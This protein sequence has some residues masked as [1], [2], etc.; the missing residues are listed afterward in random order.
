ML[1]IAF[2]PDY[3]LKLPE[4][5]RFPMEKYELL[6]KQL[7][8][9]GIVEHEAFFEPKYPEEKY[10]LNVHT[11][12]YLDNLQKLNLDRK[13]ILKMGFPLTEALVKREMLMVGGTIESAKYALQTGIGL[14]IAGGTHHAYPGHAEGFCLL[15]DHA[16]AA[17]YLQSKGLA[18]KILII[19]LDVHQG[20]GTAKIFENDLNVFTF[21]MHA[22]NN[23]P[24]KKEKSDLDIALKDHTKDEQ[25]L[26][27][28]KNYLPQLLNHYH[29]DFIFYQS[30][31]DILASD[32]LGRLNCSLEGIKERDRFV[33]QLCKKRKIP[34]QCSMGGGYST[35][36]K[37]ILNAHANTFRVASELYQ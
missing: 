31:V 28:L 21:S 1:K 19:D 8:H 9:E 14:N 6:P 15:N 3:V 5:H 17:R 24:F 29:P 18:E 10:I 32:R 33:F 2:H 13:A 23:Y 37:D 35:E 7:L 27:T 26:Q 16:I 11:P 20:N 22:A 4:G 25:Y 34:V 12:F 36:I 30:G